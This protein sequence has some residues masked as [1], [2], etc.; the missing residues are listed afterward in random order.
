MRFHKMNGAGNDYVY[1]DAVTAPELAAREDLPELSRRLSDRHT[2]IGGDG[3]IVVSAPDRAAAAEGAHARMRMFNS[4]GSE[5]Q[6]CGNGLRCVAKLLYDRLSLRAAPMKIQTG[7]GVLS[8][9]YEVHGGHLVSATIAMGRPILEP[10]RVPVD[11]TGLMPGSR[12]HSFLLP[13]PEAVLAFVPVSMG[14]PHAVFFTP[15]LVG[16]ES[17]GEYSLHLARSLGPRI[18]RHLAFPERVNVHFASVLGRG[19]LRVVSWER[20][21]GLTRA[22]GTGACAAVVAGVLTGRSDRAAV[23]RVPGGTLSVFWE[24]ESEGGQVRLTGPAVETFAGEWTD[25]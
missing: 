14:N 21:T 18:E 17:D 12:P 8:V 19:E 24:R 1:L 9:S 20:G 5:S 23:V 2:G 10:E 16:G 11:V 15:G 6:M 3:L 22:C 13:L 4:D 7:R 25:R